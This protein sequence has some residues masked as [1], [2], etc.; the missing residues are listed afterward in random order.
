[1]TSTTNTTCLVTGGAGFIGTAL[2]P[3]LLERFG[4]VVALDSLLE[5]VHP[6]R[7][8]PSALPAAV[9]RVEGDVRDQRV[10]DQL[11]ERCRPDV[12][13]HLAAE[14]G[15]GQSIHEAARHTSVN[16]VGTAQML[17]ALVR[18]GIGPRKI[19]LTSSRAVY[20]E[21]RWRRADGT[22]FAPGQRTLAD[23]DAGIW[24]FPGSEP[25]PMAAATVPPDPC[26]VYG[27]TKVAQEQ[28]LRTWGASFDV[29]IA[30]VRLQNVY[31]PGQ[32]LSNPYTG[33]MS[34]FCRMAREGASIPLYEDGRMR[35][36]FVLIDDVATGIAAALDSDA[37]SGR[38][39]DIGSGEHQTIEDAAN[40]IAAFYHA[41]APHVSGQY[42]LGDVRHAWAD[43]A[44]TL[45]VLDWRPRYSL[46][47]GVNRLASW[48]EAQGD[49][50]AYG[51][52]P[53]NDARQGATDQT[54]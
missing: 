32:S 13:V 43:I 31:G 41:P 28:L 29:P 51:G 23:L 44:P 4:H 15:T 14:T 36:D 48:I 39:L 38:T 47:D 34:L 20:G 17:D 49:V 22:P 2:A 37:A 19:L 9:E 26:S 46:T 7:M 6:G 40:A 1:V 35:R 27:V 8:W 50:P 5:Q 24:D 54:R 21:G 16:V 53:D 45:D 3:T 10:W 30:I 33:I 18:H 42:R 52:A 12:I 11:F 25:L